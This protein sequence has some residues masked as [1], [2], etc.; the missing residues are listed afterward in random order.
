MIKKD[1]DAKYARIQLVIPKDV[2][3]RVRQ[4]A[5]RER[6]NTSNMIVA[7][8]DEAFAAR[9]KATQRAEADLGNSRP[10]ALAA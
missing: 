9:E 3:E 7:L 10:E 4:T 5:T 6:R 2:L 8:L 1:E